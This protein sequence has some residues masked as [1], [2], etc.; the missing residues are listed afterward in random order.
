MLKFGLL[1]IVIFFTI[2][3]T[4]IYAQDGEVD[5]CLEIRSVNKVL[6]D[7]VTVR[8]FLEEVCKTKDNI[9]FNFHFYDLPNDE[10]ASRVILSGAAVDTYSEI[11]LD[12][13]EYNTDYSV[14]KGSKRPFSIK[15]S[16]CITLLCLSIFIGKEEKNC[17]LRVSKKKELDVCSLSGENNGEVDLINALKSFKLSKEKCE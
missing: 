16:K 4:K 7:G 10:D 5:Q 12:G 2:S 17:S 13:I 11:V 6:I 1:S 3:T 9:I 15:T 14:M 8:L